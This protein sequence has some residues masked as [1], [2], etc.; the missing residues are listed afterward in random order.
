M[1]CMDLAV[2]PGPVQNCRIFCRHMGNLTPRSLRGGV[3]AQYC[4]HVHVALLLF[5]DMYLTN[6]PFCDIRVHNY[7]V[8]HSY[9]TNVAMAFL[10]CM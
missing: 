4:I 2:R 3:W 1:K 10:V 6:N 8:I 9:Y 7:I 5:K